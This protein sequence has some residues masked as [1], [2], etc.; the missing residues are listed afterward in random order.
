ME[1]ASGSVKTRGELK[2]LCFSVVRFSTTYDFGTVRELQMDASN[3][4]RGG[5]HKKMRMN[6]TNAVRNF[7]KAAKFVTF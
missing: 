4:K 1:E 2:M 5:R 6:Y 7:E 3:A